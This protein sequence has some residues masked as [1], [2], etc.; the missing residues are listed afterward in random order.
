[1]KTNSLLR[2]GAFAAAVL[3]AAPLV[4]ADLSEVADLKP[5]AMKAYGIRSVERKGDNTLAVTL[6]ASSSAGAR[7]LVNASVAEVSSEV[8]FKYPDGMAEQKKVMPSLSRTVVELKL[9]TPMKNNC[10]YAAIAY[11][12]E[13]EVVTSG[14]TGLYAGEDAVDADLVATIVGLRR[15]SSVGEGKLLCEFGA[16]YSPVSGNSAANWKVTVNGKPRPVLAL[17]RRSKIDCYVPKGWGGTYP[18]LMQHDVF[19]DIGETLKTG[20]KVAVEATAAVSVR[21]AFDPGK[22]GRLS[23]RRAEVCLCRLLVRLVPRRE[24]RRRCWCAQVREY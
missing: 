8:E 4:A 15:V 16:G 20:D 10:K 5:L 1:M 6:G 17:G 18:C 11:G 21:L 12:A 13:M 9:P 24:V 3:V 23:S 7:R 14:R 22:P 19:L 2:R